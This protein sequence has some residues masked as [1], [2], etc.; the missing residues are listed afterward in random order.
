MQENY[1]R[2]NE[3]F[4]TTAAL[5]RVAGQLINARGFNASIPADDPTS[6]GL[7][8]SSGELST[9]VDYLYIYYLFRRT[10]SQRTQIVATCAYLHALLVFIKSASDFDLFRSYIRRDMT[11]RHFLNKI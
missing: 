11:D 7:S 10:K 4:T 9:A 5:H 1:Q 6:A 3:K 8:F 2:K